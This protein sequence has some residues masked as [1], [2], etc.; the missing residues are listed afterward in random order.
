MVVSVTSP[1]P[2]IGAFNQQKAFL[3]VQSSGFT[4]FICVKLMLRVFRIIRFP[5]YT[6]HSIGNRGLWPTLNERNDSVKF[7]FNVTDYHILKWT[8]LDYFPCQNSFM[9][10]I[11][12]I[13]DIGSKYSWINNFIIDINYNLSIINEL[14]GKFL[15]SRRIYLEDPLWTLDWA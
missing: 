2:V 11:Y 7:Y 5:Y 10:N 3:H 6:S 4:S 14:K 8:L 15:N 1:T 13:E 12:A 9:L